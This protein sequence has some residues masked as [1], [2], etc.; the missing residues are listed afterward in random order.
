MFP[1][2]VVGW[3]QV[4]DTVSGGHVPGP[5]NG[6]PL[7]NLHGGGGMEAPRPWQ[8]AVREQLLHLIGRHPFLTVDQLADLLGMNAARVRRLENELIESGWLRRIELDEFPDTPMR[9]GHDKWRVLGLVEITI[10]GRRLLASWLGLEPSGA[11]RYHGLIGNARGQAGRRRR[12]LR[13]LAHTLGANAV[14]V[15]LALA[16]DHIRRQGG[17][18]Q[19]ADWRGAA[20]C[21]RRHCK[22]DGYGSYMRNGSTFGFFLEYDRGTESAR[23]YAAK[24]R[25]YYWYRDSGQATRDYDGFPTLL[26]VTTEPSAEHRIA[27]AAYRAWFVRGTEPLPV[28][29]TTTELIAGN[30][31]SILGRI[32]RT[33]A[34]I[35]ATRRAERQYWFPDGRPRGL[36]GADRISVPTAQLVWST[37]STTR[38]SR[39]RTYG[40]VQPRETSCSVGNHADA[41]AARADRL[42]NQLGRSRPIRTTRSSVLQDG[43]G[44]A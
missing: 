25:A 43:G 22:P 27:D 2:R 19:L 7:G 6:R 4:A 1:A 26:F 38:C 39:P 33:P 15:A 41:L 5:V 37:A 20:A 17:T 32:W 34:P 40:V 10:Q 29:I 12:L 13:A 23:Q 3:D 35:G 44:A 11:T 28:L 8:P 36:F 24:F 42:D 18:D 14:F 21:E 16:A 30:R 9:L 31:D